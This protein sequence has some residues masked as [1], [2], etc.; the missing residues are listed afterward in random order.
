MA[1]H[2]RCPNC[3]ASLP[4]GA[5]WCSLCFADLRSAPQP[6]PEQQ[7]SPDTEPARVPE[8]AADEARAETAGTAA[9]SGA[10]PGVDSLLAELAA[11]ESATTPAFVRHFSSRGTRVLVMIL[12]TVGLAAL[13]F[14][15]LVVLGALF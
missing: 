8:A 9:A 14:L 10:D 15:L 12:G 1:E 2:E 5:T 7:L 3:G 4:A 13:L 6:E 11:Q